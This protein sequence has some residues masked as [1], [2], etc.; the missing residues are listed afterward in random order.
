VKNN[1]FYKIWKKV[2][3]DYYQKGIKSNVL[4]RMWHKHKIKTAKKLMNNLTFNKCLDVGCASGYMISEIAKD[5][6][7][8]EFWGI[9]AYDKAI[10]Y[11]KKRYKNIQFKIAFA[12]K[13]PFQEDSFDLVICYETIEH[14][15]NPKQTLKEMERILS[16]DGT[17]LLAMDSGNL[18]FRIIWFIWEKTKGS[19]WNG[20]HLNP[21]HHKELEFLIRKSGFK[22]ERKNFT[23]FGLEIVF[24]LSKN[25]ENDSNHLKSSNIL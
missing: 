23:H 4:Q 9:D 17:V 21:F 12:E 18:L 7:K 6:P 5:F 11:A 22:I 19:V 8:K 16:N 14:V 3:V 20:A 25:R 15:L 10:G 2:P 24:V 1:H 13:L